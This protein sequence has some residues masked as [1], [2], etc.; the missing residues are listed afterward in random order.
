MREACF[1]NWQVLGHVHAY[2]MVLGGPIGL[3][4]ISG[5]EASV[6]MAAIGKRIC[7]ETSISPLGYHAQISLKTKPILDSSQ[8]DTM[9]YLTSPMTAP[10]IMATGALTPYHRPPTKAAA[11]TTNH[12]GSSPRLLPVW[13]PSST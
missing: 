1:T 12:Q 9:P 2:N 4:I 13:N 10:K 5:M 8:A 11:A 6:G 7:C 3:G